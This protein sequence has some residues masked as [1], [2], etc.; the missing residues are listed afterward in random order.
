[1]VS[2]LAVDLPRFGPSV[3]VVDEIVLSEHAASAA[4]GS[5]YPR[6]PRIFDPNACIATSPW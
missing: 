1:M 2:A 4:S 6:A 3:L 5:Q